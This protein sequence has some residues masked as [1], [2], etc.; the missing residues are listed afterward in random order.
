LSIELLV[1][2]EL[3]KGDGLGFRLNEGVVYLLR[4]HIWGD[5]LGCS[6]SIIIE[7]F[8]L[9]CRLRS[10]KDNFLDGVTASNS[11]L[12]EKPSTSKVNL[13]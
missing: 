12:G 11:T 8:L 3:S 9:I 7:C 2:D 1:D 13:L 10:R 6:V 5:G 4:M